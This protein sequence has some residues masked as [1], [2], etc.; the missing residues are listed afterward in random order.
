MDSSKDW[1]FKLG[2]DQGRWLILGTITVT[3]SKC[4]SESLCFTFLFLFASSVTFH[5]LQPGFLGT[6]GN[7]VFKN[8]Q[9]LGLTAPTTDDRL[10]ISPAYSLQSSREEFQLVQRQLFANPGATQCYQEIR[11]WW[12]DRLSQMSN[13]K[14]PTNKGFGGNVA[15]SVYQKQRKMVNRLSHFSVIDSVIQLTF[16][17]CILC[18]MHHARMDWEKET[19]NRQLLIWSSGR[20]H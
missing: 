16:V 15:P 14:P 9:V 20:R 8:I 19:N 4:Y 18:L 5:C 7:M 13:S 2:E 6:A 10:L 3:N 17:A 1:P 12:L 11:G